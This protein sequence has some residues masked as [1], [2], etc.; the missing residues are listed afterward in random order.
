MLKCFI[1]NH[2]DYQAGNGENV[3]KS[4]ADKHQ[5]VHTS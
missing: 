1:T 4:S 3:R 2:W 5:C